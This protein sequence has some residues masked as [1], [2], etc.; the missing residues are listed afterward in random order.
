MLRIEKLDQRAKVLLRNS[1][2]NCKKIS[3]TLEQEKRWDTKRLKATKRSI[4][5]LCDI[6]DQIEGA[7]ENPG[8]MVE[9]VS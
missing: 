4:E 3:R 8:E 2:Q 1:E 5:E 9:A 6:V 7:Y